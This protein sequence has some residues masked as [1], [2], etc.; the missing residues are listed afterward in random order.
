[1]NGNLY[2]VL[3]KLWSGF[4]K[5]PL[6]PFDCLVPYV[7]S[8][9]SFSPLP[10]VFGKLAPITKDPSLLPTK[11]LIPPSMRFNSLTVKVMS[12]PSGEASAWLLV[13]IVISTLL[14]HPSPSS[15]DRTSCAF[16]TT[17]SKS[18]A[19][20]SSFTLWATRS[21]LVRPSPSMWTLSTLA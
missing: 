15:F 7:Y 17:C 13:S 20:K 6:K 4:T 18:P 8:A 2:I 14:K 16:C 19:L 12:N 10:N 21:S 1:M 5:V 3:D 11:V 9:C